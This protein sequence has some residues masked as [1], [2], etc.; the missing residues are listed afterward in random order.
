MHEMSLAQ[1][2]VEIVEQA[3]EREK[4]TSVKT[5]HLAIGALSGV[6][7]HALQFALESMQHKSILQNTQFIYDTPPATAWCMHC[8]NTVEIQQRGQACP[9]CQ[10]YLLQPTSGTELRVVDMVVLD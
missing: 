2:I 9:L 7:L 8:S 4:F 5:L 10:S 1:G 3:A 6:E